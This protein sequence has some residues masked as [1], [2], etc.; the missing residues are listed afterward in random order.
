[1]L[2]VPSINPLFE[3][4]NHR[5]TLDSLNSFSGNKTH[6]ERFKH[7]H[8]FHSSN[9]NSNEAF[10]VR[11][12]NKDGLVDD[13]EEKEGKKKVCSNCKRSKCLKLYCD[14]FAA[15]EF[16]GKDCNCT[17]CYNNEEH[18][19]ERESSIQAILQRNPTAFKPKVNR[20]EALT[21]V[22]PDEAGQ[23]KHVKGCNCKKSGCLKKYCECFQ[24]GIKCSEICRCEGCKNCVPG[25][26]FKQASSTELAFLDPRGYYEGSQNGI[27][28]A[29]LN[30][31]DFSIRKRYR[32]PLNED[33]FHEE[34]HFLKEEDD[35][36]MERL[37]KKTAIGNFNAFKASGLVDNEIKGREKL[38]MESDHMIV[39]KTKKE[40]IGVKK[41]TGVKKEE[42]DEKQGRRKKKKSAGKQ[43]VPISGE[44]V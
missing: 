11:K 17:D 40:E 36:E 10:M 34:D 41:E 44:D 12:K 3:T 22:S 35:E 1:M 16:C 13:N 25:S 42:Y 29:M 21:E 5:I 7:D 4:T 33:I 30:V 37:Q 39:I 38:K 2:E 15:G 28:A 24:A 19:K 23:I 9:S 43:S 26:Y 18:D 8:S 6:P 20:A 27:P 32:R 31:R 14:C